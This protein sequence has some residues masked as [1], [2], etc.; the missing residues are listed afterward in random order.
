MRESQQTIFAGPLG[1]TI[2]QHGPRHAPKK[3]INPEV[4]LW[5]LG[6][7]KHNPQSAR[8][9]DELTYRFQQSAILN[10]TNNNEYR[11]NNP[12]RPVE[13]RR[14]RTLRRDGTTVVYRR[15]RREYVASPGVLGADTCRASDFNLANFR[16]ANI[17]RANNN[18]ARVN[19]IRAS[20]RLARI[21]DAEQHNV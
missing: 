12:P 13:Q 11:A 7:I 8:N 18:A 4:A 19:A 5:R 14:E 6:K 2:L 1:S 17:R 10:E 9:T 16:R 15:V 3:V 20:I 21:A